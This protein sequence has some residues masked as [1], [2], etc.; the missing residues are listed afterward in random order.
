MA[1]R[2]YIN[3]LLNT[4][5]H[6]IESLEVQAAFNLIRDRLRQ[7]AASLAEVAVV[8]LRKAADE[9]VTATRNSHGF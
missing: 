3:P 5:F 6:D 7:G 2:P 9:Y 1:Y 4:H 8:T